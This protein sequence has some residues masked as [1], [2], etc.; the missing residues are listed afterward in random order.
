LEGLNDPNLKEWRDI[1][2]LQKHTKISTI[3]REML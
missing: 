3:N 2:K 1:I